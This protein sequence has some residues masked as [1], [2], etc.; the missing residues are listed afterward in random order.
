MSDPSTELYRCKA[1][2]SK[3]VKAVGQL[4]DSCPRGRVDDAVAP[5]AVQ[6]ID[7]MNQSQNPNRGSNSKEGDS[8]VMCS[9]PNSGLAD[10]ELGRQC[11]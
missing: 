4:S 8:S 11:H 6:G 7:C 1:K 10:W 2:C 3:E 9:R 5:L